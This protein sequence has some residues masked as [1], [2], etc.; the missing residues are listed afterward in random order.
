M[1]NILAKSKIL[2]VDDFSDFR[3][4]VKSMLM[5]LGADNIDQASNAKEALK[6]CTDNE[7][8]IILCDYNLGPEQDGQQILEELHERSLLLTGTLFLMVT[9]ETSAAKVISAIEYQ[10]NTYLTKPFTREQLAQRL[11][12]L[13]LKNAVLNDIYIA[14]DHNQPSTAIT[15]C[16]QAIIKYPKVKYACLRIKSEI[17]EKQNDYADALRVFD[18]VVNYQPLLWA[19]IGQ[20]RIYF[21]Q[22][23]VKRALAHFEKMKIEHPTQVSVLDWIAQCQKSLG[24][25]QKAETMILAALKISPKSVRRQSQL[26]ETAES[27][28]HYD[29][30]LKAYGKAINEGGYSCLLNAEHYQHF[31]MNT[32]ELVK[33]RQ[34]REQIRLLENTDLVF[35]KMEKKL[36]KNPTAMA[37]NLS[38]ISTIFAE[39]KQSEKTAKYL[40]RLKRNLDKPGCVLTST[41]AQYIESNL[42][43]ISSNKVTEPH[44]KKI[45]ARLNIKKTNPSTK[46]NQKVPS[47]L[48]NSATKLNS[49]GIEFSTQN[50]PLDALRKF[51]ESI[52]LQPK[53]NSYLLNAVQVILE[54]ETLSSD[55]KLKIE[56]E[57]YIREIVIEKNDYLWERYNMLRGKLSDG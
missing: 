23:D 24:E 22:K 48:E 57:N 36:R 50:R 30:A 11:N 12:R 41:E 32:K 56:A 21:K 18:E 9:A 47:E 19:Q 46:N 17:H 27:L 45:S 31:F 1:Q 53:K 44:L 2:I 13:L 54:S 37:M 33:Q 26:G 20:G 40:S 10:P 8:H 7:Y 25:N 5:Q 29:I 16:D 6:K 4:S 38:A 51:R 39:V 43:Q 3:L 55:A 14:L 42:D 35:N 34:G 52:A 49:E 28:E 15:L